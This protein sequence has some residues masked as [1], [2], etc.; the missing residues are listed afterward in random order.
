MPLSPEQLSQVAKQE[1]A[2]RAVHQ[3]ALDY[4]TK[5]HDDTYTVPYGGGESTI[6]RVCGM[7]LVRDSSITEE[8]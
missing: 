4:C 8:E 2:D 5:T 3:A 7:V 1:E 6:C